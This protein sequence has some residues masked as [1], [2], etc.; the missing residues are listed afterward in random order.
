MQFT[1]NIERGEN[2]F[3]VAQVEEV[4]AAISQG[5]SIDD[6]KT[7]LLDALNLTLDTDQI[8]YAIKY[9]Y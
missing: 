5:G 1:A 7:N 8:S 2:G 9:I 4:P 3:Y 6:L